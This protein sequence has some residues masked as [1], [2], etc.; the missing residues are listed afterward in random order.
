[1]S[2]SPGAALAALRKRVTVACAVCAKPVAVTQRRDQPDHYCSTRCKSAAQTARRK[3]G[4]VAPP[5]D[6]GTRP[7]SR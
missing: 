1:M 5:R 2:E 4:R 3:A 6:I 7:P